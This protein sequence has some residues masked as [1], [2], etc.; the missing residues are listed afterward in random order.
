VPVRTA[1][2]IATFR[3]GSFLTVLVIMFFR[4]VIPGEV[5]PYGKGSSGT[6][7]PKNLHRGS[8]SLAQCRFE[9]SLFRNALKDVLCVFAV[10]RFSVLLKI[11][12]KYWLE[13][14]TAIP[15]RPESSLVGIFKPVKAVH[16]KC[17]RF[18]ERTAPEI[19]ITGIH[20]DHRLRIRF[21]ELC[22]KG[23]S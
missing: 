3:S 16:I 1:V 6:S 14:R 10:N 19:N 15:S 23:S 9:K 22:H 20:D 5:L 8:P 11:V 13:V 4:L 18:A 12:I 2:L 17:Q 7:F 21:C